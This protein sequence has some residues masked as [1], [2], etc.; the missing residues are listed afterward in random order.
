V[1]APQEGEEIEARAEGA[2]DD[3]F[4]RYINCVEDSRC[5]W[6]EGCATERR[7]LESCVGP[8]PY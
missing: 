1:N 2:C 7:E 8:F 6:L 3:G 4:T 5:E